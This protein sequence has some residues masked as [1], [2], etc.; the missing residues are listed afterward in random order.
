MKGK[1][2]RICA[3]A[4]YLVSSDSLCICASYYIALN[5]IWLCRF[6]ILFNLLTL[7]NYHYGLF[8]ARYIPF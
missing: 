1:Y 7:F 8:Q 3:L 5:F 2:L 6:A 4:L